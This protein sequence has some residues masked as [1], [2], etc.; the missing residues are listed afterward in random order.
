MG[1]SI[2]II[3]LFI[4]VNSSPQGQTDFSLTCGTLIKAGD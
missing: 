1:L 3:D 4:R 2:K